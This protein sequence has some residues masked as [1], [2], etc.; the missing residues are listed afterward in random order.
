MGVLKK[1][2]I[3]INPCKSTEFEINQCTSI[4]VLSTSYENAVEILSADTNSTAVL[5]GISKTFSKIVYPENIIRSS[6]CIRSKE[7]LK[8]VSASSSFSD[9][10]FEGMEEKA[11]TFEDFDF[12]DK[13][14]SYSTS[15]GRIRRLH[16]FVSTLGKDFN[17]PEG[18]SGETIKEEPASPG[19][20]SLS[21]ISNHIVLIM[22]SGAHR[23]TPAHSLML[24]ILYFIKSVRIESSDHIII[25]SDRAEELCECTDELEKVN[26]ELLANVHFFAG[27]GRHI[28]KP[29]LKI[30]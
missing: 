23:E 18:I 12:Q 20:S 2:R 6:D 9:L 4:F 13:A 11:Q 29:V 25:L 16:S 21:T 8:Q 24:P 19:G 3:L 22:S 5:N 7:Y 15:H 17:L 10:Q 14:K 28:G 27:Y 1:D 30:L 26:P